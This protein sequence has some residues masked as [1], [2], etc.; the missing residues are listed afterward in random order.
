MKRLSAFHDAAD[1]A[2]RVGHVC[3]IHFRDQAG[4]GGE[5]EKCG[6][7][8]SLMS[9][10]LFIINGGTASGAPGNKHLVGEHSEVTPMTHRDV[11]ELRAG[12]HGRDA[13]ARGTRRVTAFD[14]GHDRPTGRTYRVHW[15]DVHSSY[16]LR[17]GYLSLPVL[18]RR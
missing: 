15:F 12:E 2:S 9:G 8:H 11:S 6:R 5:E 16:I 13:R 18:G 3:H 14:D 1:A 4:A 7:P 10:G 17:Y